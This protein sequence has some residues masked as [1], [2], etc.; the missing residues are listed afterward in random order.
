M[1][2]NKFEKFLE[3]LNVPVVQPGKHK[4]PCPLPRQCGGFHHQRRGTCVFQQR[5]LGTSESKSPATY[6]AGK[7]AQ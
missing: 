2:N 5:T 1:D 6:T 7:T 3:S 4:D